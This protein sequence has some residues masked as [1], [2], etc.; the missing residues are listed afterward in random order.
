MTQ[1]ET[2]G[3]DGAVHDGPRIPIERGDLRGWLARVGEAAIGRSGR[4]VA[5][6]T[7]AAAPPGRPAVPQRPAD[8]PSRR[9][10]TTAARVERWLDTEALPF[11]TRGVTLSDVVQRVTADGLGPVN[12]AAVRRTLAAHGWRKGEGV[13]RTRG[14]AVWFGSGPA[15]PAEPRPIDAP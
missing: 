14:R 13:C 6:R 7:A 4:A 9:T 11:G 1:R 3:D 5:A 2:S 15:S 10:L 8:A 12:V